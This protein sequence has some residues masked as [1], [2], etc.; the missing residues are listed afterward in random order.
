M[1]PNKDVLVDLEDLFPS[2]PEQETARKKEE[3]RL[4]LAYN[5]T[6]ARKLAGV[7]QQR[8]AEN[9]GKTQ[10][11]VSKIESPNHDHQIETIFEYLL[12]LDGELS[13]GFKVGGAVFHILDIE[14]EHTIQLPE[15]PNEVNYR[16][17]ITEGVVD[18]SAVTVTVTS[19]S[20]TQDGFQAIAQD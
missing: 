18:T 15:L 1:T 3:L 8:V 16:V 6:A 10:S 2:T 7:S 12:A 17:A 9:M 4:R 20:S 5:M 13:L 19:E 14:S 11:W